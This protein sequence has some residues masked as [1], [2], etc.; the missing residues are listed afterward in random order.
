VA[1]AVLVVNVKIY[2]MGIFYL[3]ALVN[4]GFWFV[5]VGDIAGAGF[6]GKSCGC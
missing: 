1:L 5:R 2:L 4:V 3:G 6:Y